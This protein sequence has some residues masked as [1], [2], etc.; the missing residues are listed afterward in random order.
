M[1]DILK[2]IL[3]SEKELSKTNS[4]RLKKTLVYMN[5]NLIYSDG[6]MY[7]TVESLIEINSIKNKNWVK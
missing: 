3:M 2:E 7:L 1:F 5:S 4:E 6:N